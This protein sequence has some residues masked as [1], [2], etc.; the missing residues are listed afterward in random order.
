MTERMCDD[1]G[2]AIFAFFAPPGS[3]ILTTNMRDFEPLAGALG[4]SVEKP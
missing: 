3:V 4:K 2:D 1:L